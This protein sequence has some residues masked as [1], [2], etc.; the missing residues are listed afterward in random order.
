MLP[1]AP[2]RETKGMVYTQVTAYDHACS[3]L[4]CINIVGSKA[5]E[6]LYDVMSDKQQ[7]E[8]IPKLSPLKQ[9]SSLQSYHSVINHF[10]PKLMAF[11]YVG[12]H[13]R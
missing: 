7:L 13:C 2:R 8:D 3:Y 12:M 10:A 1:P 9:T 4:T 5:F 11:S 6:L